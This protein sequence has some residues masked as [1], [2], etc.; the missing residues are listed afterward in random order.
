MMMGE[1]KSLGPLPQR[2]VV[3]GVCGCGKTT[4]GE[5]L[6]RAL[7][8][9]FRDGDELHPKANVDKMSAGTPLTDDDRWPWLALVGQALA[10]PPSIIGCSALKRSYRDTINREAGGPVAYLHLAGSRAVIERR[11]GAREGHFMPTSLIDSQF[12]ALEPPAADEWSVTVD[13]D[14]SLPDLLDAAI[15]GLTRLGAS[16]QHA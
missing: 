11:M 15:A 12:A 10:D 6:S 16:P 13:I 4:V 2:I 3:M 7:G 5:S 1:A 9:L 8:F 14:Q